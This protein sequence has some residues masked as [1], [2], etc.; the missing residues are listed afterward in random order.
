MTPLFKKL[1]LKD[2]NEILLLNAP[3][4]FAAEKE[5]IRPFVA[6]HTDLKKLKTTNFVLAFVTTQKEIDALMPLL[7]EKLEGDGVLWLCYPKGS[8]K[9]YTCDFN[10]DTGWATLGKYGFEPVRQVA[11]DA[12]WSALRFRRVQYIKSLT[13]SFALTAEGQARIKTKK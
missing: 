10:R 2:Q 4:S 1:N 13:R 5:Q 9:K 7:A 12:D 8:S 11:I 6:V 3:E